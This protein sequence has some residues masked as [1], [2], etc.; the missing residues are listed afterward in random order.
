M[1]GHCGN[2]E[3]ES[4]CAYPYKPTDCCNQRKFRPA[5]IEKSNDVAQSAFTEAQWSEIHAMDAPTIRFALAM[6]A[7]EIKRLRGEA[8]VLRGLLRECVKVIDTIESESVDEFDNL[9]D[10]TDKVQAAIAGAWK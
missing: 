6:Q 3:V 9:C 2:C 7:H 1:N 10:L 5:H 8:G 4:M